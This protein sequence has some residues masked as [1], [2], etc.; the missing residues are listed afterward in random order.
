MYI[1]IGK[2]HKKNENI[3]N[4]NVLVKKEKKSTMNKLQLYIH[5]NTKIKNIVHA[6]AC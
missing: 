2:D 1:Y 4:E 6:R 3:L 5:V